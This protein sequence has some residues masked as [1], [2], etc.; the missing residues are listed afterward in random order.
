ML[1][2]MQ[3]RRTN[4]SPNVACRA[5]DFLARLQFGMLNQ[6]GEDAKVSVDDR[7]T[8]L[9]LTEPEW[10]AWID[11]L[12]QRRALPPG[13]NLP[14]M[15]QRIARLAYGLALIIDARNDAGP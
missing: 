15:L 9:E 13:P 1:H 3:T 2:R 11:F 5:T 10:Q 7:R 12:E 4:P 6:L 8:A 14:D